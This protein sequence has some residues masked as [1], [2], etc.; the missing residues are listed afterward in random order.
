MSGP[1]LQAQD[2]LSV[3]DESAKD[4]RPG[5]NNETSILGIAST[6][7]AV[8]MDIRNKRE[9]KIGLSKAPVTPFG[10]TTGGRP[11]YAGDFRGNGTWYVISNPDTLCT[12][13]TTTGVFTSVGQISGI[14]AG[15]GTSGLT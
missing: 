13:D 14:P 3:A 10:V 11:Y 4:V 12:V 1:Q 2:N 9:V 6:S 7:R 8:A 15:S 5:Q